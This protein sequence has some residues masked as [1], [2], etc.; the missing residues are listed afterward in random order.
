MPRRRIVLDPDLDSIWL[1]PDMD[2]GGNL[3]KLSKRVS[4]RKNE[5]PKRDMVFRCKGVCGVQCWSV[6]PRTGRRC[7]RVTC[8]DYRYCTQHLVNERH[9]YV[10]KRSRHL[11]GLHPPIGQRGLYAAENNSHLRRF[12]VQDGMPNEDEDTIVFNKGDLIDIY[13]GEMMDKKELDDRYIHMD[14][15]A[16]YAI[17]DGDH[18]VD[19]FCALT[20]TG[21]SN[22]PYNPNTA[23]PFAAARRNE[24]ANV[25]FDADTNTFSMHAVKDIH[26]GQEILYH[27]G[28]IYWE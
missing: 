18:A 27:Y 7:R 21:Y 15:N 12:G 16:N 6:N 2:R 9:L 8:L 25:T 4:T 5:V 19:A 13:G 1:P 20:A 14:T 22:D 17:S 28:R 23:R 26:H 11:S 10:G 24:N 3:F